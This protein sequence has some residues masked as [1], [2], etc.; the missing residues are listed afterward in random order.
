MTTD[1]VTS[2][3]LMY[4]FLRANVGD[5]DVEGCEYGDHLEQCRSMLAYWCYDFAD[6]CCQTCPELKIGN[7][8]PG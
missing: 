3:R 2:L 7:A 6:I 1:S 5:V 4:K 8:Q